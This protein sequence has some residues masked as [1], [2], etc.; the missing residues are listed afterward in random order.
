MLAGGRALAGNG[1]ASFT[2]A[3]TMPISTNTTTAA[4]VQIQKGDMP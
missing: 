3:I 4:W 1:H 2:I